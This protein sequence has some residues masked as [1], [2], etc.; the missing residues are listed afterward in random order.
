[1]LAKRSGPAINEIKWPTC[2][3][4]VTF[5]YVKA[6]QWEQDVDCLI[7]TIIRTGE[8]RYDWICNICEC[9]S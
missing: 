3:G 7:I 6:G 1:M 2:I 4:N 8:G 9:M 5:Y